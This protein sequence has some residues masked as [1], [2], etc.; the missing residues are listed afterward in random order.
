MVGCPLAE[1]DGEESHDLPRVATSCKGLA[2]PSAVSDLRKRLAVFFPLT[3][4]RGWVA[5]RYYGQ[6]VQFVRYAENR[7][8]VVQAHESNP[9]GANSFRPRRQHHGLDRAGC[10]GY[11]KFCPLNRNNDG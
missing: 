6:H 8:D 1:G 11:R 10:I 5:E 3:D 9:V 4:G 7:L 2:E